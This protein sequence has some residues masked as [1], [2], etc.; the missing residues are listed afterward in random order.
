[1]GTALGSAREGVANAAGNRGAYLNC[2]YQ[3]R[4]DTLGEGTCRLNNGA[5]FNM[6]VGN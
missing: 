2:R 6:H 1:M 5:V 3:M 4:S